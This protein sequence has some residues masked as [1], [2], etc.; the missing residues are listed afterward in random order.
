M[1]TLRGAMP[2][3][4]RVAGPERDDL[5]LVAA[6][7]VAK[8][9]RLHLV[10]RRLIRGDVSRDLLLAALREVPIAVRLLVVRQADAGIGHDRL[11][12]AR[13]D[14]GRTVSVAAGAVELV[15]VERVVAR[16][17]VAHLV[18]DVVDGEEVADRCRDTRAATRLVRAADHAEIRNAAAGLT[19]SE[20]ADVVVRSLR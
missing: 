16:E 5:D 14:G 2:T 12:A 17:L 8:R 1:L 9:D 13:L 3:T 19:Q 4:G 15:A 10:D 18:G 6:A 7:E 11:A 20:V